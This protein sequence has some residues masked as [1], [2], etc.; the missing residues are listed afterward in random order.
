M[1]PFSPPVT[2]IKI[3]FG[4]CTKRREGKTLLLVHHLLV[5]EGVW[6]PHRRQLSPFIS[7]NNCSLTLLI[8]MKLAV[9]ED[10]SLYTSIKVAVLLTTIA[11]Y[12]NELQLWITHLLRLSSLFSF[13]SPL[14][15]VNGYEIKGESVFSC[16]HVSSLLKVFWPPNVS[17]GK[18][19][20]KADAWE[21]LTVNKRLSSFYCMLFSLC[22]TLALLLDCCHCCC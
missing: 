19:L 21:L 12:W 16:S 9:Q 10:T 15:F 17:T 4:Y 5:S 18:L 1:L 3:M 8:C 6:S 20:S 2:V 13:F 14:L 11:V 7:P 22:S